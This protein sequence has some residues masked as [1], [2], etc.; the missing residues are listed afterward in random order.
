MTTD[1]WGSQREGP[2][3]MYV[4]GRRGIR[5]AIRGAVRRCERKR[6]GGVC[7]S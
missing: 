6:M 7:T 4:M 1:D 5:E 2:V 3:R